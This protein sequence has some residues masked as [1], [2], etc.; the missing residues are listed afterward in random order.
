MLKFSVL[1]F[2]L[3]KKIVAVIRAQSQADG[4]KTADAVCAGGIRAVE[5]T[6]T[7]PFAH[8]VIKDLS[9]RYERKDILIGAGTVLD[10]QTARLCILS[11][12]KFIVSPSFC[13]DTARICN[14]YGIP[15]I[16]GVMTP[17]EIVRALESGCTLLKIFPASAL[18]SKIISAFSA[19]FP[20]AAFMPTGGITAE[21]AC[22]W[23]K[24]GAAVLG[25]GGSLTA[26]AKTGN[27]NL[28]EQA[29]KEFVKAVE[30]AVKK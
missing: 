23:I 28:V 19:P 29:A 7:V 22:E 12:A 15:Y 3:K 10:A 8:D 20:Q 11:G 30:E 2:L 4:E 18:G 16:P 1:D 5:V 24:A 9:V 6:M 13:G 21:N 25:T 14:R 17:C 26:G 27:Y